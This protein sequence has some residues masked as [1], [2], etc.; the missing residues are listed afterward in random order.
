MPCRPIRSAQ[1]GSSMVNRVP[2][3]P[4]R[5]IPA[6]ATATA[7]LSTMWMRGMS[8]AASIASATLC[9]VFVHS[10]SSSAPARS[11][12]LGGARQPGAGLVPRSRRLQLLDLGEV[13]RPQQQR[14]GVQAPQAGAGLLVRQPVVLHRRLPAHPAEQ[15]ED[16]HR[17][18]MACA[19][20]PYSG[21]GRWALASS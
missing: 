18:I 6:A 4:T 10:T 13:D 15:A 1:N 11:S 7:T 19:A 2:S 16:L 9:M 5:R 8:T 12:G 20:W 17:P 21:W 14:G 3:S